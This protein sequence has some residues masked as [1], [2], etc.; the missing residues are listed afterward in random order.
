MK[1]I[2]IICDFNKSSGFGHITRMKS[3]SKS[4]NSSKYEVTF[5]FEHKHKKFI[6]N[7]VKDLNCKYVFF[8]LKKNSKQIKSYLNKNL[9]NIVIFDS[10]CIDVELEK[11]LYKNFFVVCMDD[12][13]SKHNSHI[14]FNSREELISDKLSKPGHLWFTG[15]KFILMNKTQKKNRKSDLIKKILI[16]AGGSSAYRL[17]DNFFISSINYLSN[18]NIMIDILYNNK[19]TFLF[20]VKKINN[21]AGPNIKYRLLKFD[22]GFSKNLFKYDVVAGPAGTTTF[23]AMS[24]DVLTF[25]FPIVNDGRDSMLTWNLLGNIIHLSF[26]EKNN[27]IIVKQ[28]W[29]YIFSNY[30]M[31][32]LNI[33]KNSDLISDNSNAICE[34]INKYYNKKTLLF[35]KFE[36]NNVTYEI[37]KA[38]LKFA[39][40][41]LNSRNSARVRRVSSNPNYIITFAEH[42][43]WWKN[44]KIKK[45]ILIKNKKIPSA[46][47]W[48]KVLNK[49]DQKIII[50]GWFL[51]DEEQDTLRASFKVIKHQKDIIKRDYKGYNWL[52]NINKKNDLS[53]RMNERIGFKKASLDSFKKALDIFKFDKK[54]FN[55]YEMKQ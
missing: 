34:L 1:R 23:E 2:V 35:S 53:I 42:L 24:S 8:S 39:R 51:D 46:Y 13:V 32:N 40:S 28:M 50:S 4:F 49:D 45:F 7:H 21:L 26:K 18:K 15:K 19:K 33:K 38:K 16:H 20:L 41:F 31:L 12:K 17:M 55:V 25:S 11:E 54:N 14:V 48:I 43:N 37:K 9:I 47:H 5:L 29:D 36:N 6:Q 27:K 3:L 52:I 30:K 44:D 22:C 10:Y